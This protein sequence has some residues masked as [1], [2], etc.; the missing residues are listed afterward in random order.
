MEDNAGARRL[1][2]KYELTSSLVLSDFDI[3]TL[4]TLKHK[5]I[6][7]PSDAFTEGK[8]KYAVYEYSGLDNLQSYLKKKGKLTREELLTISKQ[9]MNAYELIQDKGLIHGN[10]KGTSILVD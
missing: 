9:L 7:P 10:I 2:K 6:L 4:M 3:K 1:L 5:N 8:F